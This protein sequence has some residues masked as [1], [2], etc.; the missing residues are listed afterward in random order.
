MYFSA[1]RVLNQYFLDRF[2]RHSE[3][4]HVE[5]DN[6]EFGLVTAD[7]PGD[8]QGRSDADYLATRRMRAELKCLIARPS[9]KPN[10]QFQP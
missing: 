8:D 6:E 10:S 1:R 2:W 3:R 7:N 9:R 5:S 4:V